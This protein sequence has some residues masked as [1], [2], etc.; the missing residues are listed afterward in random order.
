MLLYLTVIQSMAR[1]VAHMLPTTTASAV[2][3]ALL[4]LVSTYCGGYSIHLRQIPTYWNWIQTVS[5]QRWLLPLLVADEFS[6]ETLA[7]TAAN[8]LCRNKQVR[9]S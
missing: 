6:A 3:I 4:V 8:Q 5:P 9:R 7:N 2:C 1:L